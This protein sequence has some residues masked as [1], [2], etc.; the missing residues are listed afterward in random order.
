MTRLCGSLIILM[1]AAWIAADDPIGKVARTTPLEPADALRSFDIQ[2]GFRIELVASEPLIRS[3]VAIAFDENG[4]LYVAEFP[5]YNQQANPAFREHGCI[6]LLEDTD[7]DGRF[8]RATVFADNLNAPVA[9]ACWDGGVFVGIVPDLWYFK[10]TDGDDKADVKRLVL[11]G[12]DRDK[13]GEGMLNSFQWGL[14]NRLHISTGLAGGKLRRADQPDAKPITVRRQNLLLDARNGEFTLTSGGGQHGLT[15]DHWGDTFVCDNSHPIQY[16]MYDSA[17]L[18]RNRYADAVAPLVDINAAGT[19]AMLHRLSP[20]EPWREVR[21]RLRKEKL[22]DGPLE[23]GR[24]FG[25]FT[26]ATGLTIYRGD[27]WPVEYRGDLFVG[28]VANNLVYRAK[29]K[30]KALGWTAMRADPT[31]EFLASRDIWFRPVQF[32]N[33]P[34][35]T[36]YVVDMYR[37]LI[38][39]IESMPPGLLKHVDVAGGINRGRIYRIVPDGFQQPKQPK[40]GSMSSNE[41]VALLAHSNGWHRDTAAR[42]LFQRQNRTVES[43][44]RKLA[45]TSPNPIG[46]LHANSVLDGLNELTVD[47]IL[48]ALDDSDARIRRR[49]IQWAERFAGNTSIQ[50]RVAEMVSD[51][52][53]RVRYQLAFSLSAFQGDWSVGPLFELF[54]RDGQMSWVRDAIACSAGQCRGELFERVTSNT[55]HRQLPAANSL[56]TSIVKQAVAANRADELTVI[57]KA[58]DQIPDSESAL[59]EELVKAS[60]VRPRSAVIPSNRARTVLA[61]M[62][63][64][65]RKRAIDVGLAPNQRVQALRILAQLPFS[66]LQPIAAE[67]LNVRQPPVVQTA[68]LEL[69]ASCND[70]GVPSVVINSWAGLSPPIRATATETL[71]TRPVWVHQLLDAVA[72]GRIPQSDI[73]PARVQLIEKS[74]DAEVQRRAVELFR[75]SRL[76][77]RTDV[78]KTYQKSLE[79]KG[80]AAKGKVVFKNVCSTC[81]RLDGEGTAVGPDL[82]TMQNRGAETVLVNILDPN[83]E[84][85]P[86]YYTYQLTTDDGL[87]IVGLITAETSNSVTMRRADAT[88]VSIQRT[89]IEQLTSTGISAMP[90]GL[91]KQIDVSAMADLLAYLLNRP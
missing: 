9:V 22:F 89:N 52:D 87:S 59:V 20:P 24:T 44:V 86:Q 15:M 4:R 1:V 18:H 43:E 34:D 79:L 47:D 27:A 35:G 82:A 84:V 76:S 55:S 49:A 13:A 41:L 57:G 77:K 66:E 36:L 56:L 74:A 61:H 48:T 75:S 23:G 67:C 78:L 12:F 40:L 70:R 14:D 21:T 5:E 65:S 3:P 31:R 68:A 32:A 50:K 33:A 11:T 91:E 54:R 69:L 42:L 90:D 72:A 81:H 45:K 46:R 80:D 28:E 25:F 30:P 8:D 71:L 19:Q 85:L 83:R 17:Y 62:V 64:E 38:E 37:E 6:K 60:V 88:K 7:G 63:Q 29:L 53:G 58:L 10:D 16:F 39:T 51:D 26:G 73:D 2:P